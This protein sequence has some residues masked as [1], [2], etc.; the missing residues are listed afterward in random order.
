MPVYSYCTIQ[1]QFMAYGLNA[2]TAPPESRA[3]IGGTPT[4]VLLTQC[5]VPSR[6]STQLW[7]G[8]KLTPFLMLHVG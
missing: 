1:Q 2:L 6:K 7:R 4:L 3:R 5:F 8:N